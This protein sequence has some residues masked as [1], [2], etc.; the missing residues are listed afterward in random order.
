MPYIKEITI[1]PK[2]GLT[3]KEVAESM[4]VSTRTLHRHIQLPE[5]DPRHLA[6]YRIG[7]GEKDSKHRIYYQDVVDY[8]YRNYVGANIRFTN[9]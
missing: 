9:S 2:I 5:D 1:V 8:I 3:I 6:A 7:T 4:G